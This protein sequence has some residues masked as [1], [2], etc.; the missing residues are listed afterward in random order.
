MNTIDCTSTPVDKQIS[1]IPYS[2]SENHLPQSGNVISA[3]QAKG[4]IV[5]YQA[6]NPAIAKYAVEH[7]KLGGNAFSFN[8]M[9]WIKPNYLWMM[10]RSGWASK[11]NQERV[12]AIR[13]PGEVW[14]AILAQAVFSAFQADIYGS[15]EQW[16]AALENSDVRLQ[17]DPNHDAH[18]NKRDRRAIQIGMKDQALN[19][20]NDHIQLIEDIT[21]FVLKQRIYL[22]HDQLQY[23]EVPDERVYVPQRKDLNIGLSRH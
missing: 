22:E 15:H 6:Y 2:E 14:E 13:I 19:L 11:E 8:R 10:Y 20:F 18:G 9:T 5:V 4:D 1:L 17:W 12:L 7:Q 21:P 23:L 16:K 3:Y